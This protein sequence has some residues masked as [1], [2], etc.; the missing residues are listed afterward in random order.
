MEKNIIEQLE[1]RLDDLESKIQDIMNVLQIEEEHEDEEICDDCYDDPCACLPEDYDYEDE[2]EEENEDEDE[3]D[4][5][6]EGDDFDYEEDEED[7]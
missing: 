4:F 6:D 2:G 3:D 1:E 7:K 5:E